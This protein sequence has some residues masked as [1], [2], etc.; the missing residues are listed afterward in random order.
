MNA[1]YPISPRYGMRLKGQLHMN[2]M[3]SKTT[4]QT[5]RENTVMPT[6]DYAHESKFNFIAWL[7]EIEIDTI[8]PDIEDRWVINWV[9]S[10]WEMEQIEHFWEKYWDG[11]QEFELVSALN[12]CFNEFYPLN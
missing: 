6:L 12:N 5:F 8:Y 2:K 10:S 3:T 1:V 7:E 4:N 9:K 11:Q